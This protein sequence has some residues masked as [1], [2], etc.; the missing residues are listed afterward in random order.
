MGYIQD[1]EVRI[2]VM[3]DG[4]VPEATLNEVLKVMKETVVES[5]KN[6]IEHGR[7][8]REETQTPARSASWRGRPA[9]RR[10]T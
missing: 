10:G 7:L 5:Y 3:L 8:T 4:V 2:R 1:F 9:K 6:G